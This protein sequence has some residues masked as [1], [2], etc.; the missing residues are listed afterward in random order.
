MVFFI[1]VSI[2]L[3]C[4]GS[5]RVYRLCRWFSSDCSQYI[6]SHHL[7][8]HYK[9]C[10]RVT[11]RVFSRSPGSFSVSSRSKQPA[12]LNSTLLQAW[13]IP[14]SPLF[15]GQYCSLYSFKILNLAVYSEPVNGICPSVRM[16]V[17]LQLQVPPCSHRKVAAD[18]S[19]AQ[20]ICAILSLECIPLIER[21]RET[22]KSP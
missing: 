4:W 15:N 6:R 5:K 1:I 14:V 3:G 11:I 19:F 17:S 16:D 20:G 10:L 7:L 9:E 12:D 21:K 13:Y 8:Y 18:A 2:Q 22:W